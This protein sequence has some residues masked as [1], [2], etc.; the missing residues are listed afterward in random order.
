MHVEFLEVGV[1]KTMR[2][3]KNQYGNIFKQSL[4]L[5]CTCKMLL[6]LSY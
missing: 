2:V 1:V 3:S 6:I 5:K 4:I